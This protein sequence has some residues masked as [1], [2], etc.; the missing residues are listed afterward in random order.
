MTE[1][2]GPQNGNADAPGAAEDAQD[3]REKVIEKLGDKILKLNE[4]IFELE[5]RQPQNPAQAAAIALR[6][7]EARAE[8]ELCE[9]RSDAI[10]ANGPFNDPGPEAEDALLDA[11]NAVDAATAAG[12]A[13]SALLAATYSLVQAYRAQST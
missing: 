3:P 10:A 11:M 5:G 8:A 6:L 7:A 2:D 12:A 9:A 13:T 4:A 1:N